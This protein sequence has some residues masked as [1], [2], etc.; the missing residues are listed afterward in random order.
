MVV[1]LVD[2]FSR[3]VPGA[4]VAWFHALVLHKI[5][6]GA[7]EVNNFKRRSHDAVFLESEPADW[8]GSYD[9]GLK[10]MICQWKFG[11]VCFGLVVVVDIP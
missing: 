10:G 11:L 5:Q 3:A 4:D 6:L 9:F 1:V 2:A 7:G 8:V